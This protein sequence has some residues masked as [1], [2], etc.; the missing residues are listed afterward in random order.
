MNTSL[1]TETLS[2]PQSSL[3]YQR[4]SVRCGLQTG[5]V[6]GLVNEGELHLNT[7]VSFASSLY[8]GI[9]KTL[10][11]PDERFNRSVAIQSPW[12]EETLQLRAQRLGCSV[13]LFTHATTLQSS[14]RN[15]VGQSVRASTSDVCGTSLVQAATCPFTFFNTMYAVLPSLVSSP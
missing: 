11:P 10:N 14:F 4:Q 13:S 15:L 9:A 12:L 7:S 6:N 8:R 1:Q 2:S 5:K 3:K